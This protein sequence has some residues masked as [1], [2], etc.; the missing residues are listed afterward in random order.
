[1]NHTLR[2]LI[3]T[4]LCVTALNSFAFAA[5]PAVSPEKSMVIPTAGTTSAPMKQ[6][7]P[8]PTI[9]PTPATQPVSTKVPDVPPAQTG[10]APTTTA[11]QK[12]SVKTT[13]TVIDPAGYLAEATR[14]AIA[15]DAQSLYA[16]IPDLG[17]FLFI[18]PPGANL[19][20]EN[21]K[22][23]VMKSF[24][25]EDIKRVVFLF[26]PSDNQYKVVFDPM[27]K[28]R[29]NLA[30]IQSLIENDL[31]SRIKEKKPDEAFTQV[32]PR[33]MA[34]C[35]L[36]LNGTVKADQNTV[37][38]A[39]Y[40]VKDG[41]YEFVTPTMEEPLPLPPPPVEKPKAKPF[42]WVPIISA[43][44]VVAGMIGFWYYRRQQQA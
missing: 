20:I 41:W 1:M 26:S 3:A 35:A 43:V 21:A 11:N 31:L 19:S 29:V 5:P 27:Y 12:I 15:A 7:A 16:D 17:Y 22:N 30:L 36:S 18:T 32:F 38:P 6:A 37:R 10:T 14:K 44:I 4:A 23:D 8:P 28:N 25:A 2:S 24:A 33:I 34:I 40:V 9:V 13:S 39:N 42:P